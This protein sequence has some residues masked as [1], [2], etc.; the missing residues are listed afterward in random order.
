MLE[1]G[2]VPAAALHVESYVRQQV[3]QGQGGGGERGGPVVGAV[4]EEDGRA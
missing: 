2:H 1:S 4:D 3:E